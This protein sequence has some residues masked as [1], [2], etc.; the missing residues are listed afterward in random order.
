MRP[1]ELRVPTTATSA[2]YPRD[3]SI[4]SVTWCTLPFEVGSA[5][6]QP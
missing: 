4:P 6:L 2:V 3:A 5:V 1:S